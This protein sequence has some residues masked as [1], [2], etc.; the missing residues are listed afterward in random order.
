MPHSEIDPIASDARAARA[1]RRLPP[2]AACAFCGATDA[3]VLAQRRTSKSLLEIHHALGRQNDPGATVVL[4]L[5]C[6]AKA[7]QAQR[8]AGVFG[9]VDQSS[10]LYRA[11]RA[12]R[13]L[14]SLFEVL[15]ESLISLVQSIEQAVA[16]QGSTKSHEERKGTRQ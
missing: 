1:A 4:C 3:R 12:L 2:G 9:S 8:D 15:P 13:S 16:D 5:N 14:A 6:H 7:S 11:L 10:D